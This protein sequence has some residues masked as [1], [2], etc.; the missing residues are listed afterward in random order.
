MS[1][2]VIAKALGTRLTFIVAAFV[3]V[4]VMTLF[5]VVG[6][7]TTYAQV[8]RVA[9]AT[10]RALCHAGVLWPHREL[11]VLGASICLCRQRFAAIIVFACIKNGASVSAFTC[12]FLLTNNTVPA[13]RR[14][15]VNGFSM[16][17]ASAGK[18][19]A[20]VF[21]GNIF[22]CACAHT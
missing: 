14:G 8:R 13:R 16:T 15:A 1:H 20:P 11:T 17:V 12:M 9:L 10:T 22:A 19:L 4:P 5:P 2:S 18:A 21:A 6:Y 3:S 7:A